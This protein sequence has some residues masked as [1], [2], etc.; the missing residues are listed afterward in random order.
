MRA[1]VYNG[2][3]DVSVTEVPDATIEDPADVVVK[4]TATNICGSDLH[5]YEGRT[6]LEPGKVIGHENLG[7]VI[8]IGPAVNS[9]KVGDRVCLPFNIACGF[10]KNC[11]R[12]LTGF[13]LT[14]NPGNAG[15]A[16]GYADM[17]PY[18]GGQAE[19]LR[20][21]FADF[22]ALPLPEDSV[23]KENDYVMLADIFPTGWHGTRLAGLE[24]G[25]TVAIYGAGPVGTMAAY[26]AVIQGA[27]QVFVV[28][29][30]AERLQVAEK[31][32]A[33]GI[34]STRG[35]PVEQI[36]DAT[37]GQG[38]DRGVEAVGYQAHDSEGHERSN[39]TMNALVDVVRSTGGI[40][41]VGVFV[42]EDPEASDDLAKNGQ[43][44]FDFGKF[45]FKGQTIGTG[46]ANVKAYNQQLRDLV[47]QGKAQPSLLVSHNLGLDD[48]PDAYKHF[49]AR[50]SGW[51]KVVLNP[52]N[53]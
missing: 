22:N 50:D 9:I 41:V 5:M 2:P 27:S 47:H 39:M 34:D 1:V 36:K 44:A 25:D 38:V 15:G 31:F 33:T 18:D 42:P 30:L 35:D 6:D 40:G 48:A 14:V 21:P 12:G 23:D 20:V 7:E 37:R 51:T 52:T 13:C 16:Y 24:P 28:D 11:A 49:D 19:L 4:I 46:Q 8:E 3:R 45:F 26:S 32:G 53:G 17:G 10:C 29:H 43:M